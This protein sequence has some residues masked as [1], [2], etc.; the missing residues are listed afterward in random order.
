M[1]PMDP[2]GI[3]L[4]L[5]ETAGVPVFVGDASTWGHLERVPVEANAGGQMTG[6]LTSSPSVVVP[7]GALP[8]VTAGHGIEVQ[9]TV[10]GV[11]WWC[12]GVLPGA[13]DGGTLRLMLRG[14]P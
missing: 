13:P 10:D 12:R 7:A 3:A 8:G 4:M 14:S 5:Q 11:A 6:V 9:V 1:D 2:Q